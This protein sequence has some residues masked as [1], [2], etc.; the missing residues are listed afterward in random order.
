VKLALDSF[1]PKSLKET[2]Q[3]R[4]SGRD[5]ALTILDAGTEQQIMASGARIVRETS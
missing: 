4:R 2:G 5:R 3:R 1:L